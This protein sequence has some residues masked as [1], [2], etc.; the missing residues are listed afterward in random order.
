MAETQDDGDKGRGGAFSSTLEVVASALGLVLALGVLGFIGWEAYHEGGSTP[1]A[2]AV[3]TLR[4]LPSGNGYV[5]EV[6]ARNDSEATAA[7][8]QIEGDLK[9][10][11][12]S[13]EKS[14]ATISYVPGKSEREAGLFF[15]ED[16]RKGR[17]EVRAA[18]YE[19]P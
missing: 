5:V 6:E 16:P 9:R 2:I 14:T 4:I 17:L 19:K 11:G 7:A 1:P 10:A 12:Q 18:G 8:V 3:H 13:V 15:T